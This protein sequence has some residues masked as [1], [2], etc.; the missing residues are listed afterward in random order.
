MYANLTTDPSISPSLA[1]KYWGGTTRD[2]AESP[3][4]DGIE[5]GE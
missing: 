2:H 1:F 4:S 3:G 5:E